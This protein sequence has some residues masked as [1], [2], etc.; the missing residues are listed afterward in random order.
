[1]I[2]ETLAQYLHLSLPDLLRTG[3]QE[4]GRA[5]RGRRKDPG[6]G[7]SG[8]RRIAACETMT[9]TEAVVTAPA[10]RWG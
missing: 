8:L 3:V 5:P 2:W 1:M 6:L 4:C 7:R 10:K 9:P